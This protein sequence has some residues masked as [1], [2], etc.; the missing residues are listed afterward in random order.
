MAKALTTIDNPFNPFNQPAEWFA[1]DTQMGYNSCGLLARFAN[2]PPTY[3]EQEEE[4]EIARAIDE[5]V[6]NDES[7]LY[8][9]IKD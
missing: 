3:S 1:Y 9:S 5:I 8:I 7:G 2:V 4:A 6:A